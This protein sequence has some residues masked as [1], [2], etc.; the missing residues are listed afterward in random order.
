MRNED[1]IPLQRKGNDIDSLIH[2]SDICW[3]FTGT[4]H[5]HDKV[6]YI[7]LPPPSTL[8]LSSVNVE[9]IPNMNSLCSKE[10][11]RIFKH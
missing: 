6:R 11:L 4:K 10:H 5:L 1:T 3:E 7:P 2:S 9:N 8:T